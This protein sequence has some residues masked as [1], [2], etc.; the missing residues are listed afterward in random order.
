MLSLPWGRSP[1]P[2]SLWPAP[3]TVTPEVT[4]KPVA[5]WGQPMSLGSV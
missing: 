1:A 4:V 3:S 2:V 5:R